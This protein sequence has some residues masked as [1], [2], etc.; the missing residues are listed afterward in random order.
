MAGSGSVSQVIGAVVDVEFPAGQ[1]PAI[2]NALTIK[3]D[4][5]TP[6]V[7]IV[8]E[9]LQHLGEATVRCVALS[10]TDGLRRGPPTIDTG[11]PISVPVGKETLGRVFNLLGQP[12]DKKGPVG[13]T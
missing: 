11:A 6:P 1:L 3:D 4:T 9:V 12:I 13:T 5:T 7:D 8:L 10:S 2:Y